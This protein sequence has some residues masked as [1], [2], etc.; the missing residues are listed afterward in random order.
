MDDTRGTPAWFDAAMAEPPV[1]SFVDV[2]GGSIEVLAWGEPDAPPLILIHGNGANAS[3]WRPLGPIL[4]RDHRVIAFSWPGMGL[5]E[6][7]PPYSMAGFASAL[8]GVADRTGLFD[9]PIKPVIAAHSLGAGPT[10]LAVHH[11]GARFAGAITLDS[12]IRPPDVTP[13]TFPEMRPHHVYPTREAIF[14][15]YRLNPPQPVAIPAYVEMLA[16]HAIKAVD[17]G[18]TWRF[19][20]SLWR[21]FQLSEVWQE[22]GAPACPIAIVVGAL[23]ELMQPIR[24]MVQAHLPPG[25]PYVEI[26]EAYHHVMLDQPIAVVAAIRAF[27]SVWQR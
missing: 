24:A 14:A 20:P 7:R 11:H 2:D 26:P 5:S 21:R 25:T 19:D 12:A 13:L 9:H 15:K 16:E 18:W 22:Y 27:A 1:T 10:A 8:I 3:V 6:W 23:S 17:G 4:G